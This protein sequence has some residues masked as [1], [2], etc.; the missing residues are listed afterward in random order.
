MAD[1]AKPL[2]AGHEVNLTRTLKA[3]APLVFDCFTNVERF[4][5][6]WGPAGCEN[7]I[8]RFD[9]RPG[10]EI[11]LTMSGPGFSHTMGGEFVEI[12][13]PRRLVFR[14]MA[15]EAPRGGW[16]IVNRNT[17]TFEE[18]DGVTTMTLHTLVEKAA[19]EVVLGALGGMEEGWSQSL[20]R[21]VE[22]ADR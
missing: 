14:T 22:L 10:G 2:G 16:G 9:V 8:H 7:E 20:D 11:S 13:P 15:F 1:N 12:E 5:K 18:R 4:A 19:G 3:P 17:I 6:W 21:L